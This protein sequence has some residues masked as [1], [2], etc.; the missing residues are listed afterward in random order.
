MK[1][2]LCNQDLM[3]GPSRTYSPLAETAVYC[4]QKH[5][6]VNLKC[7]NYSGKDLT[8]PKIIVRTTT[9]IISEGEG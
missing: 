6:C 1:C 5:V 8:N 9:N 3:I 4:E 2:N 7:A